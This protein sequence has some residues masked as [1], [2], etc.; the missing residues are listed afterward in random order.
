MT[1]AESLDDYYDSLF[2]A[3]AKL[4]FFP[5]TYAD[6]IFAGSRT[7]QI[8]NTMI[9]KD[10][11][12]FAAVVVEEE[13]RAHIKPNLHESIVTCLLS[14]VLIPLN[15]ATFVLAA[16]LIIA[17]SITTLITYPIAYGIDAVSDSLS[18]RSY[19]W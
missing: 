2:T 12:L 1:A 3:L 17:A 15:I 10:P 11:S 8:N 13:F 19:G 7:R 6:K 18:L 16:A 4:A 5:S 14:S 9:N